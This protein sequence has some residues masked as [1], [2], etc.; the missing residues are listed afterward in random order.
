GQVIAVVVGGGGA[1][2]TTSTAPGPGGTSSF[3]SFVSATGG[4]LNG[5][6]N[7]A[8]PQNGAIPGGTGVGGDVNL[9]GSSGGIGYLSVGGLGGGLQ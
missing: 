7:V 3:G 9:M 1:A 6:A 4:M 2:G 5:S 8:N